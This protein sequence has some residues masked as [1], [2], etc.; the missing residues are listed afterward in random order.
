M[1]DSDDTVARRYREL[2]REEP[3]AAL[4]DAILAAS[5][6]AVAKPSLSRRWAAPVSIAAVL[7]LAFG[8]TLEM[9][10]EVPG[11][12]S[13][14]PEKPAPAFAPAAKISQP[15]IDSQ[16]A[17]MAETQVA[18]TVEPKPVARSPSPVAASG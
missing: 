15:P 14:A 12:E 2:S 13:A 1:T 9:Q 5:R 18:A 7:V 6:R 8:V 10:R 11:I 16:S 4:D 3:R 17:A